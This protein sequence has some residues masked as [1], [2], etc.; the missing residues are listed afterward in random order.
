MTKNYPDYVSSDFGCL[1]IAYL[2]YCYPRM[3]FNL[4]VKGENVYH[5]TIDILI[6]KGKKDIV[7]FKFNIDYSLCLGVNYPP[8]KK[9]ELT[10]NKKAYDQLG[11]REIAFEK[12]KILLQSLG[13]QVKYEDLA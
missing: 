9:K 5:S 13:F 2:K 3:K 10:V 4:R 12:L 1:I 8:M 11:R 7:I 6:K